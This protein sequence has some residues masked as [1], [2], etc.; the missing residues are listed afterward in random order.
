MMLC[1][2]LAG[3]DRE[4]FDS[5]VIALGSRGPIASILEAAGAKVCALGSSSKLPG[6]GLLWKLKSVLREETPAIVQTWLYHS[7]LAGALVSMKARHSLFWNIRCGDP[8][9]GMRSKPKALALRL[10]A[11]LSGFPE[12]IVVN[13]SAGIAFHQQIGYRPRRWVKIPNGFDTE[14]FHPSAEA[15]ASV[16]AELGI[17]PDALLVGLV[18][19]FDPLKDH[20]SFLRAAGIL[21]GAVP[22]IH[23][24]LVGP[25]AGPE[26]GEL[27]EQI[28]AL[29]L[30][31]R[32]HLLGFRSDLPRLTAALDI[33]VNC[34]VSEGFC[35]AIGEAM[36]CAVPCV[37]TDV[38]DSRELVGSAGLVVPVRSPSQLA[39]ACEKL[40][41]LGP[42]GLAAVG[43]AGRERITRSF[44]IEGTV[45]Q[46]E[47]LYRQSSRLHGAARIAL[48]G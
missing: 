26:C 29:S 23:F 6:P 13:S 9:V 8:L 18:A 25:G 21:T 11:S 28:A 32:V 46:Y 22:G 43:R 48:A 17:P 24:L 47:Q 12:A 5:V 27:E 36:A 15:A 20:S 2:L 41:A 10:L 7:D 44:S 34:S 14:L 4:E 37:V 16:R 3:F 19:R 1:R 31:D 33:A 40:L 30:T 42:E 39:A 35:N 45:S 38:G